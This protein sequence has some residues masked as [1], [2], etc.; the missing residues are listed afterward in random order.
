MS[1]QN[2]TAI[3]QIVVDIFQSRTNQQSDIVHAANKLVVI[4]NSVKGI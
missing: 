3:C 1:V 4:G 2:C